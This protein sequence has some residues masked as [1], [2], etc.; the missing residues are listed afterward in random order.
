MLEI[1]QSVL[2]LYWFIIGIINDI[3]GSIG[4][5][6]YSSFREFDKSKVVIFMA[7]V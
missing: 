5:R 6:L 4:T 7:L 2:E 3:G 1:L